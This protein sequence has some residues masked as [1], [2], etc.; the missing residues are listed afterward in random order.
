VGLNHVNQL[1][2]NDLRLV[3]L[4]GL[5]LEGGADDAATLSRQRR[6]LAVLVVLALAKRPLGREA[7]VAMF[8]GEQDE[9]RA[10]HSLT[11]ALSHIRRAVGREAIAVRITDVALDA[12]ALHV[13][14]VEFAEAA[15][16]GDHARA[17]ALYRGAF[18][19]GVHLDDAPAFTDWTDRNRAR[20]QGLF[21][22]SATAECLALARARRWAECATLA[23]R[24]LDADPT[25]ADAALYRLNAL[26]AEGDRPALMQAVAEYQRLCALLERD[27]GIAP[28]AA[29]TTLADEAARR[30]ASLPL[31]AP[32][33]AARHAVAPSPHDAHTP[34]DLVGVGALGEPARTVPARRRAIIVTAA[35]VVL[36]AAAALAYTWRDRSDRSPDG[37]SPLE[38]GGVAL[39]VLRFANIGGDSSS[40]YL[41]DGLTEEL[42]EALGGVSGVRIIASGDT[43]PER[44]ARARAAFARSVGADAAVD[45]SVRASGG[46][47]RV[48]VRMLGAERA[49]QLWSETYERP[50]GDALAIEREIAT[51]VVGALQS[52]LGATVGA[53]VPRP[54]VDAETYDLYLRGRYF[55]NRSGVAALDRAAE[56]Y[57]RAIDRDSTYAPAWAGLAGALLTKFNWGFSYGE[58]VTPAR[59]FIERALALDPALSEA[60]ATYAQMLRD[61]WRWNDSARELERALVLNPSDVTALHA[62]AHLY[63]ALQRPADALDVSRRA[64]ALDP[65]NPRI[66]MHL[67]VAHVV[68]RQYTEALAACRRGIELDPGFPDSHAKLGWVLMRLGRYDEA[69][70]EIER[71]M[72]TAGRTPGYLIELA[73]LDVYDGKAARGRALADSVLRSTPPGRLQYPLLSLV[74]GKL[75]DRRQTLA[76]LENAVTTHADEVEEIVIAPELDAFRSDPVYREVVRKLGLAREGAR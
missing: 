22:R 49:D 1:A 23:E 16:A 54:A 18:L 30:L 39:T 58:T 57:R 28:D 24:W 61:D 50:A 53:V 36:V 56:Y 74:Y 8:W 47:V 3:T 48:T 67:C 29:V 34:P 46:R 9:A 10:R 38:R 14:A 43:R 5:A 6:K 27:F 55:H 32:V 40:A 68:A 20:L 45:G 59:A 7:L 76:M 17:T 66:G 41:A 75:G 60:H 63:F 12:P 2:D 4:G 44:D 69:R 72:S 15:A 64:I 19:D 70:R 37:I 42:S 33:V 71:E 26:K 11:E 73:L 25:S 31:S 62:L 65:T 52:R 21:V 35:A 51:A 13:D